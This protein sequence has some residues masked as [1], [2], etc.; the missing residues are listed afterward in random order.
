MLD[1]FTGHPLS[2][3]GDR[4]SGEGSGKRGGAAKSH[5]PN[6]RGVPESHPAGGG[7]VFR[8]LPPRQTSV[9]CLSR[10]P[11]EILSEREETLIYTETKHSC[12][13]IQIMPKDFALTYCF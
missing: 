11:G 8:R 4:L 13:K 3:R 7:A 9:L 2:G 1:L 12:Q 10:R 5:P 6:Q